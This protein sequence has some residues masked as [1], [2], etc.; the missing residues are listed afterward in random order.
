MLIGRGEEI[1][2]GQLGHPRTLGITAGASAPEVLIDEVI[3]AL[4]R[5]FDVTIET[6]VTRDEKVAFKLPRELRRVPEPQT[7][8]SA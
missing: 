5:R 2:V 4:R 6:T 3:D 7:R 8:R 1:D